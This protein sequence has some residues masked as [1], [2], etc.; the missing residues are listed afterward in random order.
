MNSLDVTR[1]LYKKG[2]ITKEAALR[3]LKTR[4]NLF[5]EATEQMTNEIFGFKKEGIWPFGGDAPSTGPA[6]APAPVKPSP[7]PQFRFGGAAKSILPL[8][9]L[10]GLVSVG[11]T[12]AKAGLSAISD[13]KL[14]SQVGRSYREMY[15]EYPELKEEKKQ[16]TK[17]FNMMARFAPI[18]AS[19]PIVAGTWVKQMMNANV[20]DPV[21]IQQLI[22][23]QKDWENTRAMKSPII[24]LTR[25][26]P[27][28]GG[29]FQK[30]LAAG[31]S[32]E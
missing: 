20:V 3:I 32:D 13:A 23:A 21:T 19:S 15:K 22:S 6:P 25:E 8:L 5:K 9:G 26:L 27:D 24:G 29:I 18:L 1:Y 28:S 11:T 31:M 16:S 14:K 2:Y 12:G 17:F 30:A 7:K 4:Q 10:A